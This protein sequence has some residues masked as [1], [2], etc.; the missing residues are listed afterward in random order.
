[1]TTQCPYHSFAVS[2][3]DAR[4]IQER[5]RG[6]VDTSPGIGAEDVRFVGG[7]DAAFLPVALDGDVR[8]DSDGAENRFPDRSP[9]AFRQSTYRQKTVI[10]AAVVYDRETC[11]VA[12]TAIATAPV[13]FPY[14]PGYLSFREGPAV[15][16]AIGRLSRLPDCFIFDGCGIAHPRGLGLASHMAVLTGVPS[17]G[18]AKSLLCGDCGEPGYERGEWTDI[19]YHGTVAGRCIRTRD[20]VRP[21]YVSPGSGTDVAG[22]AELVLACATRYRL[23]EPTRLAHNA[24]T[25]EKRELLAHVRSTN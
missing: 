10:A 19:V 18:C 8:A 13:L 23:P 20:G 25:A 14:V 6:L 15:L 24:V 17:A 9:A 16:A 4:E 1:M 3:A 22:A 2:F 5:L 7:V 21:V 11:R 12:E